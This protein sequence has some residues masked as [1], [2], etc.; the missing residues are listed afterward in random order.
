[1]RTF[2]LTLGLYA[3]ALPLQASDITAAMQEFLETDIRAWAN[4]QLLVE[5]IRDQNATTTAYSQADI[6]ALD[7]AWRAE[8][9]AA[10]TP[11]IEPV[12]NN[13]ASDFLRGIVAE[14]GGTITEIFVMD[15]RGLNVAASSVTS[16]FWQGDEAKF[17]ETFPSGPS[18]V[19]FSEIEFDESSQSYQGQIS[20]AIVDPGSQEVVGAMTV[21]VDAES[22]N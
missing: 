20:I 13:A 1:M 8:V 22:L 11:T 17:T 5:A 16:D 7:Q 9:G 18:G 19:H 12:I 14:A 4:S 15:A 6:D 2:A 3:S 10:D 21:G